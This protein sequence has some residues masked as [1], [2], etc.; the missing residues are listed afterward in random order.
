[1][2]DY[3]YIV[4]HR[5][6]RSPDRI[7]PL[8]PL[9]ETQARLRFEKIRWPHGP[10]CPCCGHRKSYTATIISDS[11]RGY[12]E[13]KETFS[14]HK[15][16]NHSQGIFD[17]EGE[18]INFV[19]SFNSLLRRGYFG[20]FHQFT[21]RHLHRYCVE[22]SYKRNCH[23]LNRNERIEKTIS[24]LEGKRM[25]YKRKKSPEVLLSVYTFKRV[26]Y[27]YEN[28]EVSPMDQ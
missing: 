23:K 16:V 7:K 8:D 19:E 6:P 12:C 9:Q 13:V 15:K 2:I 25:F 5:K 26:K 17:K 28:L 22:M 14:K 10:V 4:K 21:D 24:R 18:H 1:M 3:D 27:N 11:F 20:I